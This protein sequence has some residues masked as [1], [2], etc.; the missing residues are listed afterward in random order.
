MLMAKPVS[1]KPR[2]NRKQADLWFKKNRRLVFSQAR[3]FKGLRVLTY[4]ELISEGDL[5][6]LR[7]CRQ[8]PG[9]G[10][11][12]TYAV[13]SIKRAMLKAIRRQRPLGQEPKD[14]PDGRWL[15]TLPYDRERGPRPQ[16]DLSCLTPDEAH[17]VQLL[18]GLN[19]CPARTHTQAA[20]LM[21]IKVAQLR[22]IEAVALKWLR[23]SI[24]KD[25]ITSDE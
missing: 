8:W 14:A 13:T 10:N 15:D 4:D 21:G 23:A 25:A 17:A 7:V 3:N 1:R 22:Q 19:D 16:F 2:F 24:A 6:L 18:Y 20:R 5:A 9:Q 12:S 11:F